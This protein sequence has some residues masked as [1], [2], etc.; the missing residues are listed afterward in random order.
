LEAD[1]VEKYLEYLEK[2]KGR[3]VA[4][5]QAGREVPAKEKY[6]EL[7]VIRWN[8]VAAAFHSAVGPQDGNQTADALIAA[9]FIEYLNNEQ[10]TMN[11]EPND[12][13]GFERGL[14]A[15]RALDFL[16]GQVPEGANGTLSRNAD[17]GA[18]Q[19]RP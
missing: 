4:L 9:Q 11:S 13:L 10:I 5:V 16:F 8:M 17:R 19:D 15:Y 14:R 12:I 7:M 3:L 6:R 1:Q 2:K 18:K